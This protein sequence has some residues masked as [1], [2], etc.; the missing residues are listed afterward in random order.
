MRLSYDDEVDAAYLR[1]HEE[2]DDL[3]PV[4]S[5][6]FRPPN[7]GDGAAEIVLDFD[8]EGRLVGIEFLAAQRRLL[9]SVLA[10]AH[11]GR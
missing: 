8:R 2:C 7:P 4:T 9:P 5:E 11:H 10:G 1:L 6:T 3:G